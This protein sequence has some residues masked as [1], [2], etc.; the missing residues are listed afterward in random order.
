MFSK[1]IVIAHSQ[2]D[3]ERG[4]S[5]GKNMLTQRQTNMDLNTFNNKRYVLDGISL[6]KGLSDIPIPAELI[7]AAKSA[8]KITEARRA[9]AKKQKQVDNPK[10]DDSKNERKKREE[11][12]KLLVT[13]KEQLKA[14]VEAETKIFSDIA[15]NVSSMKPGQKALATDVCYLQTLTDSSQKL[16]EKR[17]ELVEKIEKLEKTYFKK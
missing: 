3:V 9:E 16:R 6:F 1:V 14:N 8:R 11:D 5:D 7:A 15:N 4:F 10:V 2:A 17:V 13:L 12:R